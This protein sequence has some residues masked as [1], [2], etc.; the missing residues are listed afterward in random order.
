MTSEY[1]LYSLRANGWINRGGTAG[2]Q[3]SEARRFNEA[4]AVEYSKRALGH[5]GGIILLPV[6]VRVLQA[7]GQL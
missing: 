2:T 4:E 1:V 7:L 5:D 3:L 6:E